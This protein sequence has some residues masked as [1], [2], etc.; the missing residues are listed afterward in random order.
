MNLSTDD[1]KEIL[2]ALESSSFDEMIL[3]TEGLKFVIRRNGAG[4]SGATRQEEKERAPALVVAPKPDRPAAAAASP[5]AAGGASGRSASGGE[6]GGTV[7]DIKASML[8]TFY[9]SPKP[10]S[11]QFVLLGGQ[12][13]EGATIG[14]IEVMKLMNSICSN[15]SGEVIEICAKDGELVEYGQTL[16]RVRRVSE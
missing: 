9:A 6:G 10:G 11:A 5:S 2:N 12:V 8:G 3:E 4:A 1:V 15:V 14:I 7:V 13:L 16:F